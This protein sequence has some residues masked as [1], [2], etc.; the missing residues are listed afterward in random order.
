MV[1]NAKPT[2]KSA[3]WSS[4][5][6]AVYRSKA[7]AK[8]TQLIEKFQE[9]GIEEDTF[10][11]LLSCEQLDDVIKL[12]GK[13]KLL[14]KQ[15]NKGV[16]AGYIYEEPEQTR[17]EREREE[18]KE[19]DESLLN[20]LNSAIG[21][22]SSRKAQTFKYNFENK[23]IF[24]RKLLELHP[25]EFLQIPVIRNTLASFYSSIDISNYELKQSEIDTRKPQELNERQYNMEM[26]KIEA[27]E[28]KT[29]RS[30]KK[31]A[32]QEAKP[33][34]RKTLRSPTPRSPSS[35]EVDVHVLLNEDDSDSDFDDQKNLGNVSLR[36]IR[37][38]K[39]RAA[40]NYKSS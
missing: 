32:K 40:E 23:G 31:E 26:K 35:K 20:R 36:T 19:V 34:E 14:Q 10:R 37:R 21:S 16:S 28:R 2:T 7:N 39:N 25:I 8:E 1:K 13:T 38:R 33:T 22:S 5:K 15:F 18:A 29:L 17:I 11:K 30:P 3:A 24:N 27:T 9:A 4:D 12:L 6:G